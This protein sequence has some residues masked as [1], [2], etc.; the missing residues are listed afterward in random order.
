[1]EFPDRV[2]LDEYLTAEPYVTSCFWQK[3]DIKT[4]NVVFVNGENKQ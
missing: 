1:M 3:I 2:A 4:V